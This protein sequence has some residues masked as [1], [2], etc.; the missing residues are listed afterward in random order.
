MTNNK[1]SSCNAIQLND[2]YF[3]F[4]VNGRRYKTCVK[5]RS[6]K[7]DKQSSPHSSESSRTLIGDSDDEFVSYGNNFV[8]DAMEILNSLNNENHVFIKH[9]S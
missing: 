8:L 9:Y 4:K 3:G 5:C 2:S 1:C 6:K 7:K